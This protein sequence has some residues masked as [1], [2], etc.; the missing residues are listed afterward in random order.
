MPFVRAAHAAAVEKDNKLSVAEF[1]PVCED[2]RD[3]CKEL[4]NIHF[5]RPGGLKGSKIGR[6]DSAAKMVLPLPGDK[7]ISR[8]PLPHVASE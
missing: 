3:C 1:F 2:G 8:G 6:P 4:D 5:I 7:S